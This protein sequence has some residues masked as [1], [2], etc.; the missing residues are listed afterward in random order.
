M[1]V[2]VADGKVSLAIDGSYTAQELLEVIQQISE[3]RAQ[4]A[5]DP[6]SP[7][8]LPLKMPAGAAWYTEYNA[9]LPGH[10]LCFLNGLGW[11][12]F[13]LPTPNAAK[14]ASHLTAQV[15]NVLLS[16]AAA[17]TEPQ[18][19]GDFGVSGGHVH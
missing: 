14:L 17:G 3:A 10:M 6:T 16:S 1:K 11:Q 2:E 4:V 8:G 5:Q 18:S 9:L 19:S 12:G 13:L 7:V 15:A